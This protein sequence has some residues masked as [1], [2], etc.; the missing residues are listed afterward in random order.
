[1]A[2]HTI[3]LDEYL[4][5][6]GAD[7]DGDFLREVAALVVQLLMDAEVSQQI[8]AERYERSEGRGTHRNGYRPRNWETRVGDMALRIPKLRQGT[9]YPSFLEPRR[10]AERALMAV[11]QSAYVQGVSTRKVDDL[12]QALG[13]SGVDKSKVSR[14]CRELDEAVTAFRS[15]PLEAAYPYVWLDGLYL[16]VRQN[17]HIVNMAVVIAIG[18]RET[19][20]REILAIDIGASEEEAFW[21][22]FLRGMVRR[23]LRGVELVISDAHEGLK[24]AM[25]A[26]MA[27]AAWQ[28]CRVHVMRN[29]LAHVPRGDKGVVAVAIRTIFAQPQQEAARQQ[30]AEVVLRMEPIWPRAAAVLAAS[31]DDVLAYMAFPSDHWTRIYSTNPLERLHREVRR[32]TDVVGIFPD[33]DAVLRLVGSVLIEINDEWQV[34]RRYFSK[35]SMRSLREPADDRLT[36]PNPLRLAPIR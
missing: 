17:H 21:K 27:G 2:E 8:G 4:R 14:I 12:V 18:V 20:E 19:G 31:E 5:K 11:I 22:A 15:R 23:G 29:V 9:Y 7:S 35:A 1:M 34:G 30:L 26:V 25:Q 13:L 16:K 10:R 28:R 33:P 36:A 3:E 24:A 32:R 6:I